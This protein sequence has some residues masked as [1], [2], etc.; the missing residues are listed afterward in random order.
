MAGTLTL[1]TRTLIKQFLSVRSGTPA[2]QKK[3]LPSSGG[4]FQLAV[5][6]FVQ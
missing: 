4:G 1:K 2:Q 5:E 6:K 3:P